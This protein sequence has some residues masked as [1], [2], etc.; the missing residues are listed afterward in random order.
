[1]ADTDGRTCSSLKVSNKGL[2]KGQ[3]IREEARERRKGKKEG[4]R[5]E[6]GERRERIN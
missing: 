4:K 3:A 2:G 6:R 5:K 1:M